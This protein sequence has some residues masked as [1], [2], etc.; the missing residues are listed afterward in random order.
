MYLKTE[1]RLL[2]Y[3]D[4]GRELFGEYL[5]GD[6]IQFLDARGAYQYGT[7]EEVQGTAF[8]IRQGEKTR[9]IPYSVIE[10]IKHFTQ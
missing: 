4:E 10:H 6:E 7:I 1:K 9:R 8:I 5:D 2:A 3:D